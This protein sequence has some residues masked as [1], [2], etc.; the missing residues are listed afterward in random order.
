MAKI[1]SRKKQNPKLQQ[2]ELSDG[3]ASLYLEYYLGRTETPVLDENGQQ[4][5]YTTGAMAGKPK[6]QIKHSRKKENLNLYIWLHPRSQQERVQNKNTLALAEKIRFER[7]QTFLEDREGY[8]LRKEMD[9]DFMEFCKE[10][11]KMPSLTKYTR[12]T[13]K[14]G[15]QKFMDF[16]AATP[17]YA[18][19]KNNLK[20]T[21]L[22]VD[23]I[24]AY[25]EYLK[26]NGT[27]D[28]PKIYFRMFKRMV[29]AAVDKDLIKKN[30]CRGFVLKNDNMTLQKEILL[31][32][33]IQQ[34]V[35][36]HFEGERTEIHRAF[37]FGLYT[38]I[39][40]CDTVSLTHANVDFSAKILRF[41]QQKTEGR[42]AHSGVTIPL[43]PTLLKLIGNPIQHTSEKI[44][45]ITCYRTTAITRLQKWVKAAGINKTITWHCARH[46]FAVNVLGAGANIKTVASLMGHSSIKMTEKYLHV[47]D[48]QKQDAINS[49]GDLDYDCEAVSV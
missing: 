16:L 36:T 48:Q 38:G 6:Y 37:I 8:R 43:S 42:S 22:T 28:G 7:E 19:Y 26:E 41:N 10:F 1:E 13:L 20:M 12:I 39:R 11:I 40:W 29:T 31:P 46:S 24:A 3:R 47:I 17:R 35:A 25:V 4:V 2:S 32:E 21:Q 33:E 45:N 14:H 5:Y 30:P 15:L 44:F 23:M 34:L 27:G 9:E 18:L 49:L